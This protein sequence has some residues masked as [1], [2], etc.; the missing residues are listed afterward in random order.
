MEKKKSKYASSF[1][2]PASH[3]HFLMKKGTSKQLKVPKTLKGHPKPVGKEKS[4]ALQKVL[5]I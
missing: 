5:D 1:S 2:L 4:A 3:F